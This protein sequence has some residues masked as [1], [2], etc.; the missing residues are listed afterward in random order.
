LKFEEGGGHD[1]LTIGIIDVNF[2]SKL[3]PKIK[4]RTKIIL[5][6]ALS[7][8]FVSLILNILQFIGIINPHTKVKNS[9]D[10]DTLYL[11]QIKN[12]KE[13]LDMKE[14]TDSNLRKVNPLKNL[15]PEI[16]HQ[17]DSSTFKEVKK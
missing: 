14:P 4:M 8:L 17:I 15:I 5:W 9:K 16:N 2:N 3:K 13:K 1:N 11:N 10:T 7:L 6:V 12:Q